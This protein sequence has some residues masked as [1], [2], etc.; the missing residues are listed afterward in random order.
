MTILAGIDNTLQTT[1]YEYPLVDMGKQ[2]SHLW[3]PYGTPMEPLWGD[4]FAEKPL[5]A[6]WVGGR[7]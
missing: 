6:M 1:S 3:N 7:F 2:E 5:R 4:L